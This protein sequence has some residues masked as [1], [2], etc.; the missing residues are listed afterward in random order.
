MSDSPLG[1]RLAAAVVGEEARTFGQPSVERTAE[2][3]PRV[4]QVIDAERRRAHDA[5]YAAGVAEATAHL[6]ER[7]GTLARAVTL[8][9][10]ELL[11]QLDSTRQATVGGVVAL[12][13][14][15]AR[16]VIGR[17]PHDGGAA[18]LD[19]VEA[20]LERIDDRPVRVLVHP[21][22]HDLM[23]TAL[24]GR[25]ELSV[26]DD[27]SLLPGEVR[28]RGGW[29]QAD[30]TRAAAWEAVRTALEVA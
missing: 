10:G 9:C 3:D 23:A 28:L 7:I 30:L 5:G 22:D 13:E 25:P 19:R 26:S 20:A 15:I 4:R 24:A 2:L 21:D 12:A 18:A 8:A 29:S 16:V 11:E 14:D 6:D 27:P 1:S 17:T